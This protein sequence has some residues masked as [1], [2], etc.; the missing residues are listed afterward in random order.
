M[1]KYAQGKFSIKNPE[2]Y[3]GKGVP[4]YRS[5]WEFVM[6]NFLDNNNNVIRWASEAIR[7]PYKNPLTGKSTMYVPDFFVQYRTK[8]NKVCSEI[9]EIKPK[10][11]SL[12]EAK[13]SA[14][15]RATVAVNYAKWAAAEA[16]CKKQGLV[17]RVITEDQI[18]NQGK[19]K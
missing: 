16:F 2:K 19:R 6:M 15:D 1:A 13:A 7:I 18:F 3:V 9:V 5:S 12:I 17:F 10:K 8:N 11:Q 4:R 14:Q